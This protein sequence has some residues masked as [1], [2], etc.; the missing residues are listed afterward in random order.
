M[1]VSTASCGEKCKNLGLGSKT[2]DVYS[3]PSKTNSLPVP[4]AA[5]A[6]RSLTP[7]PRRNPGL[8]PADRR[9]QAL[10]LAVVVLP[11]GPA[12]PLGYQSAVSSP[13]C[14]ASLTSRM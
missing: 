7:L 2:A 9:I 1:L 12:T 11:A 5:A 3:S 6:P 8:R 13:Q 14:A 4:Q 10:R